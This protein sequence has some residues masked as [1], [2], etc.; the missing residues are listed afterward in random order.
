MSAALA[1]C[2]CEPGTYGTTPELR[3]LGN[4]KTTG[5]RGRSHGTHQSDAN[6][7]PPQLPARLW[8]LLSVL[9]LNFSRIS[10]LGRY[11]VGAVGF[12]VVSSD[13]DI[14]FVDHL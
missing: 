7:C 4:S 3:G 8:L 6:L 1:S 13:H 10:R 14:V 9:T 5:S 2:R 11:L 12:D